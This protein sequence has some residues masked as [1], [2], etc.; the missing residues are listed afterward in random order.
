ML[1]FEQGEGEHRADADTQAEYFQGVAA[2]RSLPLVFQDVLPD[3]GGD[4]DEVAGHEHHD[5]GL[6]DL[7]QVDDG[8]AD[9]DADEGN[10]VDHPVAQHRLHLSERA[11][12][13]DRDVSQLPRDF[14][15]DD[16]HQDGDDFR[17]VAR[18]ERDAECQPVDEV[19]D[20]RAYDIDIASRVLAAEAMAAFFLVLVFFCFIIF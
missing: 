16:R 17:G 12:E 1:M 14:V 7:A 3:V 8:Q 9:E 4:V 11:P 18:G 2:L 15:G 19:M 13:E 6:G 20:Q 10:K 5:I